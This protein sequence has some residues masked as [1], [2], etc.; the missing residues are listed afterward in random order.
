MTKLACYLDAEGIN[1]KD[2]AALLGVAQGTVSRIASGAKR[3]GLALAVKIESL[4]EGKVPVA[5][6]VE[7]PVAPDGSDA[8]DQRGAA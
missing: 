1:Q 4:T 3:P 5:S 6:W 2:F 7:L 8:E